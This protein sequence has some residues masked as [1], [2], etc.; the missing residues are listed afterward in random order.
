MLL[1]QYC[2]Y[3]SR[4]QDFV[5]HRLC[6][7]LPRCIRKTFEA[8]A[9]IFLLDQSWRLDRSFARSGSDVAGRRKSWRLP[10]WRSCEPIHCELP[11][12]EAEV[13]WRRRVA[14]RDAAF[15]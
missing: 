2:G 6:L 14:P 3:A 7:H 5:F 13:P 9:T 1:V 8:C 12:Q 10:T 4:H 15:D 11:P